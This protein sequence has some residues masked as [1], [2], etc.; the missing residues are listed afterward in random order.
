MIITNAH[1]INQ[2]ELPELY[3][4][5]SDFFFLRREKDEDI[6]RTIVDLC[7]YRLPKKYGEQIRQNIQIISPSRKGGAGTIA[8][9]HMLQ[10]ALNPSSRGK[11][12]KKV[13]DIVFRVGDKVMQMKNNYDIAWTRGETEGVGIYNGDIGTVRELNSAD[14][15]MTIVFDDRVAVYDFSMLDNLEHAYAVTVHKSQGSEYPVVIIPMYHFSPRLM[16]RNLLYTAVTRAQEMVIL[17]GQEE[18][19]AAMVNN[20]RLALRYTGLAGLLKA[21]DR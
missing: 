15:S 16:T 12:E 18:I 10:E 2:G 14:E 9:N 6:A 8:L 19:V 7:L 3:S 21:L 5:R 20:N 11:P 17:V 13:R 1:L 4:K